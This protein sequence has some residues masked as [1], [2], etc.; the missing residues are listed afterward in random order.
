VGVRYDDPATASATLDRARELGRGALS[1]LERNRKRIDD[2]NVYPVPDGDTGTNMTLTVRAVVE[3]L[4][5]SEADDAATLARELTRAALMGG[6]G[7]SG[8]IFSQMLRGFAAV[9]GSAETLDGDALASAFRSAS[10][11]AYAQ[12]ANPVEG[13]M[14]TVVRELAEEAERHTGESPSD[15][16]RAVVARGE[17]AL[18]RTQELL[19]VLRD[20]Q[21]VDA[22]GAALLELVRGLAAV[23]A[24]EPIPEAGEAEA[25]GFDAIHQELSAFRYCT[26]FVV[27]GEGLD[28]AMLEAH[29]GQMGDSLLVVGD[30][31]ALKIH[32]HTNDPGRPLSLAAG[33]GVVDR[34]EIANMHAQTE[35]REARL[36]QA[37]PDAPATACS[38][39]AVAAG[40][41]NLALFESFVATDVVEG[42]QSMNPAAADIL[43]AIDRAAST[44]VI[45]LPNNSN[46]ILAAEQAA[47]LSTKN[48]RVVG[49]RSIPAGLAAIVS[50]D[51]GRDGRENAEAMEETLRNVA[52][53]AVTR[54]SRDAQFAGL[55]V[56]EGEYLA[57]LEGDPFAV[58]PTLE[59][60]AHAVVTRLLDEPRDVITLVTGDVE[61]E[62]GAFVAA[63][64]LEHPGVELAV[65]EGG[66]PHYPLLVGAE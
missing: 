55:T 15:V 47:E 6:R 23:A 50:F 33:L 42:G 60:A 58:A 13:T 41:G 43:A 62:L 12:V 27:E 1:S 64:E 38:V 52:T 35:Q 25:L 51:P 19:P 45:V 57:L 4:E 21:V 40:A 61:V 26:S 39:V 30:S 48:V 37:A 65:H 66:Q 17:E 63:L 14:L 8:V 32:V 16:L 49:T 46:V 31:S 18:A 22:G 28:R 24:G 3:Q 5:R 9:A 54:A 59:E 7:N 20:A 2:L 53:G 56:R 34:V 11:T 44:D 10:D 29:L 36:L